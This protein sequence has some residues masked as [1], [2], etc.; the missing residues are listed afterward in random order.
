MTK[1]TSVKTTKKVSKKGSIPKKT[2][3]KT[4]KKLS[5]KL[6]KKTSKTSKTSKKSKLS[7][8]SFFDI[9]TLTLDDLKKI[10]DKNFQTVFNII[11]NKIIPELKKITSNIF[12][13]PLSLNLEKNIYWT[14]YADSYIRQ[15]YQYDLMDDDYIYFTIYLNADGKTINHDRDI[16]IS[17]SEMNIPSKKLVLDIFDEY[18][19]YNYIWSGK[20]TDTINIM[21]KK[22]NKKNVPEKL[23]D[24]DVY[25]LLETSM[26][27]DNKTNL[28]IDTNRTFGL[29]H[30]IEKFIGLKSSP[31]FGKRDITMRFYS[32]EGDTKDINSHDTK[33][34]N[35]C[36]KNK[37]NVK[38]KSVLIKK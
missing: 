10:S 35:Y 17:Y 25:P 1:K 15:V 13:I 12:I 9:P 23:K 14:D 4:S 16:V 8:E 34:I 37:L 21:Y 19:P 33:I 27:F 32:Y 20:N 36:K 22:Q 26:I 18:L 7:L 24:N 6:S 30:D 11:L 29:I 28:M 5:K 2:S 38:V 31:E 3:K